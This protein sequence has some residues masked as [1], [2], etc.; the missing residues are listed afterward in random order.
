VYVHCADVL[1]LCL[2]CP[3]LTELDISDASAIRS[4]SVELIVLHLA[5]LRY[6]ALSRCYYV[7]LSSL[8]R[9]LLRPLFPLLDLWCCHMSASSNCCQCGN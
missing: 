9:V 8:R 3:R 1:Q 6:L 7:T 2:S 5:S 4:Q